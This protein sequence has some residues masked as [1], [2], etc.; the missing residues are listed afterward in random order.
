MKK[1]KTVSR[2]SL[3][4]SEKMDLVKHIVDTALVGDRRKH[5]TE[6]TSSYSDRDSSP[7]NK[8][9]YRGSR[10][11]KYNEKWLVSAETAD[12]EL[13]NGD[14]SALRFRSRQ[15]CKDNPM[16]EGT[17]IAYKSMIIGEGPTIRSM[18]DGNEEGRKQVQDVIEESI[19]KCDIT[20]EKTLTDMCRNVVDSVC[21][22]GDVLATLPLDTER[23][24]LQTIIQLIESDRV[25]T[26]AGMSMNPVRHGVQYR[27]TGHIDG[28]W[29]RKLGMSEQDHKYIGIH[30]SSKESYNYYPK[31]NGGRLVSWLMKR[32]EGIERPNQSRQI[33]LFATC[34]D[35]LKDIEDLIDVTVIGMRAAACIMAVVKSDDPEGI[36]DG[37]AYDNADGKELTDKYGYSYSR[38]NPGS[39]IPLRQGEEMNLLD[40]KR[41]GAEVEPIILRLAKFLAMKVR[42]PYPILFLDLSEINYSSYRGGILEARK[43][44]K[45]YREW[46]KRNLIWPY[47]STRITEAWLKGKIPAVKDLNDT[48]LFPRVDWPSWG[49]VDPTKE[50]QS[51]VLSI[52]NGLSSQQKE[53]A[54]RGDDAYEILRDKAHYYAEKKRIYAAAGVMEF[55]NDDQEKAAPAAPEKEKPKE[56]ESEGSKNKNDS[57]GK[58]VS[59]D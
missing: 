20:G 7:F 9:H 4:R 10:T 14:L 1:K 42:I 49:Y 45:G 33:P 26:P 23:K 8:G 27:P 29:V 28:Y 25:S 15:L 56:K 38:M 41:N 54:E 39:I 18:I 2:P 59:D 13:M 19:Y 5:R 24:G 34:I 36:Y 53:A 30:T 21:E 57:S 31:I 12:A 6:T 37:L 44:F 47:L 40:P 16:A 48:V 55:I 17:V 32:P 50:T 22:D 35:L 3:R 58:E 43:M 51:S 52:K 46:L 11:T